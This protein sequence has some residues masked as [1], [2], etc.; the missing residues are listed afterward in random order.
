MDSL[1]EKLARSLETAQHALEMLITLPISFTLDFLKTTTTRK[2][3]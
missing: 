1:V 3:I 2:V